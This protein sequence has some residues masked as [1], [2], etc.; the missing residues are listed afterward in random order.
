M[1]AIHPNENPLLPHAPRSDSVPSSGGG[2][3]G[4]AASAAVADTVNGAVV[5][6]EGSMHAPAGAGGASVADKPAASSAVPPPAV[7]LAAAASSGIG[8]AEAAAAAAFVN[9]S[10]E[11]VVTRQ[12]N[13]GVARIPEPR[14][15]AGAVRHVIVSSV[16]ARFRGYYDSLPE[17]SLST[18]AVSPLFKQGSS[19][20]RGPV[21]LS[22]LKFALGAGGCGLSRTFQMQFASLLHFVEGGAHGTDRAVFSGEFETASSFVTRLRAEQNRVLATLKWLKV[23]IEIGGRTYIFYH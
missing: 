7:S 19:R 14:P 5:N 8:P 18:P 2:A 11:Q 15:P 16:A 10:A 1:M 23:P 4:L 21:M 13:D 20:F 6:A 12:R 3:F 9:N 17:A 22:V